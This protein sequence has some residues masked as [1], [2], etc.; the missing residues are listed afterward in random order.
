[1]HRTSFPIRLRRVPSAASSIC[2][3]NGRHLLDRHAR[4]HTRGQEFIA[5][6]RAGWSGAAVDDWIRG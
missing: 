4:V 6:A 3:R 1:L 5:Q 2:I